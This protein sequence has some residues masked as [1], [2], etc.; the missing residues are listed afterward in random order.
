MTSDLIG[1]I[2]ARLNDFNPDVR[3]EAVAEIAA[4]LKASKIAIE[5]ERDA[6]NM[7][8]HTFFSFN[9]YGHSPSSLVW[10]AK[11][12]GFRLIG[13]IDF[14]V[15]DGVEEFMNACA[16]LGV[17]GSA[18]I[19]TRV[20]LPEFSM[21]EINS[22][23]E[24]GVLY[25]IG[26][27]FTQ[28]GAPPE[29]ARILAEFRARAAQRNRE[30]VAKINAYLDLVSVDY[31]R[32]IL[33]LTPA[34]NP[35]ERH[36]VVGYI[37]AARRATND[38]AAF[39]SKKLDTPLDQMVKIVEDA[40]KLQ[41][42]IRAK[43]M[44][45]GGVGYAQ[46]GPDTFPALEP[47]HQ[48]IEVCGALP[49]VGWLDGL[50]AGEQA[51]DELLELL[52]GKGAVT[53]NIVPDRNWNIANAE[54]KRR[55]LQNL[56][57]VVAAAERHALPLNVGTEMN[58]YG[59]KLIDDFDAPELAPV[60]QAFLDGAYFIYGHTILQ[61]HAGLGFQSAWAKAHFPD[62]R[63][64]NIF[65]TRVGKAARPGQAQAALDADLLPD[66]VLAGLG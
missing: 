47:L 26:I 27:G 54:V 1:Q 2:E 64:R 7:H 22:P 60:R 3:R 46:P 58:S 34:N 53:L 31:E 41:N 59:Q 33:P 23:G 39:W 50:S 15:L 13:M 32:D 19:E 35:T 44:K 11:K 29:A 6:A 10:L 45:Q 5:P 57:D 25:H 12:R 20:I 62:R 36:L 38:A 42:L 30:M 55:K 21:R 43:L 4:L 66:E 61:R 63:A 16:L 18:G 8:C 17:R 28:T 56:Y 48:M 51:L 52:T 65:Y 24:P 40:P 14:D 37:E 49:C 9:A